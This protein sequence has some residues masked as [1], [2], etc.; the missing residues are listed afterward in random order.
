MYCM[1]LE[2]VAA[3][4]YRTGVKTFQHVHIAYCYYSLL[5]GRTKWCNTWNAITCDHN[6]WRAIHNA[7]VQDS[8]VNKVRVAQLSERC[9]VTGES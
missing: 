3:S 9:S 5:D 4:A 1:I 8:H 6:V 7:L 2:T